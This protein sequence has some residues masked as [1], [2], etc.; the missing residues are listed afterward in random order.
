MAKRIAGLHQAEVLALARRPT[1]AELPV[2]EAYVVAA[3]RPC[4]EVEQLMDA[5]AHHWRRLL[6]PVVVEHP[7]LRIGPLVAPG[8][9][10]ACVSCHERRRRQHLV[11]RTT[12]DAL[13]RHYSAH[14]EAEP[15]GYLPSHLNIAA[16]LVSGI[17]DRAL[18]GDLRDTGVVLYTHLLMPQLR[19]S[20]VAGVHGC[21]H[22]G[23][24]RDERTRSHARIGAGLEPVIDA[25]KGATRT[26]P[27]VDAF[28]GSLR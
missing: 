22:C 19:R 15:R 10:A 9:T 6:L 13:Q 1:S 28:E 24:G 17:L 12:V 27:A 5:A 2:A 25:L 20:T 4:V 23:S 3:G 18:S 21:L 14:P 26:D 8:S 11:A 16:G 7:V